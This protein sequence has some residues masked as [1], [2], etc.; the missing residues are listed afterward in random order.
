MSEVPATVTTADAGEVVI[1]RIAKASATA[2]VAMPVKEKL[3]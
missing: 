1:A 2:Q 3:K